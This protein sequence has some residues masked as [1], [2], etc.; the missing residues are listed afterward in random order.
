MFHLIMWGSMPLMTVSTTVMTVLHS[1][2]VV[3]IPHEYWFHHPSATRKSPFC[4]VYTSYGA[5]PRDHYNAF[6][7]FPLDCS[8]P[9]EVSSEVS[10]RITKGPHL[11]R[12]VLRRVQ[13]LT[14][15][16]P[17]KW[18]PRESTQSTPPIGTPRLDSA[19]YYARPYPYRLIYVLFSWVVASWTG[20]EIWVWWLL[21]A[22]EVHRT[23]PWTVEIHR[24]Q[25]QIRHPK[26]LF[27]TLTGNN[28]YWQGDN[29]YK[30]KYNY[31]NPDQI[32]QG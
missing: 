28:I 16:F 32:M 5:W 10:V 29:K 15:S 24:T 12:V 6:Q 3:H 13:S 14:H 27:S 22:S 11:H 1:T 23:Q 2:K 21:Q 18:I 17:I 4:Y 8:V 20:S 7:W 25:F 9:A 31:P 19:T 30:V 26:S